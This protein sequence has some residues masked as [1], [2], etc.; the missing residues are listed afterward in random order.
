M[1]CQILIICLEY[2]YIGGEPELITLYNDTTF[3]FV[4]ICDYSTLMRSGVTY[5]IT[6]LHGNVT[7]D[8]LE[9]TDSGTL[10]LNVMNI[11]EF[12]YA[13]QVRLF[14]VMKWRNLSSIFMLY[15]YYNVCPSLP[16]LSLSLSLS[17]LYV[18]FYILVMYTFISLFYF[19]W[20]VLC[21]VSKKKDEHIYKS[22][23][24]S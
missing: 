21:N 7:I 6:W 22:V 5:F 11:P 17:A 15:L 4:F 19:P 14:L 16:L 1:W 2:P 24:D 3:D 8:T 10:E 9:V 12:A 20:H 13:S 23:S 18:Y